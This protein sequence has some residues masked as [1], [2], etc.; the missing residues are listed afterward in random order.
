MILVKNNY[1]LL[2]K[3]S[4]RQQI[5]KVHQVRDYFNTR[6]TKW[7]VFDPAFKVNILLKVTKCEI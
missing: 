5:K 7:V 1:P 3:Q 4:V 6:S 2:N